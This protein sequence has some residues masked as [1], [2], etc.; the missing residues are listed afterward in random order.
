MHYGGVDENWKMKM[1]S[2]KDDS[3]INDENWVLF[4]TISLISTALCRIAIKIT[5]RVVTFWWR[6]LAIRRLTW[7]QLSQKSAMNWLGNAHDGSV[8]N[9]EFILFPP[10]HQKTL[11]NWMMLEEF[12]LTLSRGFP[13]VSLGAHWVQVL[14]DISTATRGFILKLNFSPTVFAKQYFR[15]SI[16]RQDCTTGNYKTP[17]LSSAYCAIAVHR[18]TIMFCAP[19]LFS[20]SRS[21]R[22]N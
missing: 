8:G 5:A 13:Q 18:E 14:A 6:V 9:S 16:E 21:C 3:N 7:L 22:Q 10:C 11:V 12:W 20:L 15:S 2:S 1:L 19:P 17:F 4:S